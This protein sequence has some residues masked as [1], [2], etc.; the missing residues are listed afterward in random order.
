MSTH[1]T[2]AQF[3]QTTTPI[4]FAE[5]KTRI[6]THEALSL[7]R[8]RDMVSALATMAKAM[9]LP[10]EFL[11][12][13]PVTLRPRLATMTAAKAGVRPGR[14]RNVMSLVASAMALEGI[15]RIQGRTREPLAPAWAALLAPLDTTPGAHFHIWRFARF[16]GGK[17][18]T[19]EGVTDAILADYLHDLTHFSLASEPD[20]GAREV[21][22][23]WNTLADNQSGWPGQKL[24]V[25]DNRST[26]SLPWEALPANL[27]QDVDEWL[28]A[29]ADPDPF[30]ERA[31]PTRRELRPRSLATRKQQVRLLIG[32]L[33]QKGVPVNELASLADV[34]RLDRT[35][36]ALSF[37]WERAECKPTLHAG[38]LADVVLMIA[39]HWV[40]TSPTDIAKLERMAERLRPRPSGMADRNV[41]RLRQLEHPGRQKALLT[42][43]AR[44][45]EAARKV[46]RPTLR[47]AQQVQIAAAIELLLHIPLRISNL[48]T[49]QLGRDLRLDSDGSY[50]LRIVFRR[51][52]NRV[53]IEGRLQGEAAR[54]MKLYLE[55]YRPLL[56][57]EPSAWLFPGANP[58]THKTEDGLRS[59]IEKAVAVNTGMDIHPHLF[60][61]IA[62][63]LILRQN[64]GN[65]GMVQRLL[66]HASLATTMKYYSALEAAIAVERYD[67]L[68]VSLREVSDDS[69]P[70][71]RPPRRPRGS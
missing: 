2:A 35:R 45:L 51:V 32:A 48:I 24:T 12:A 63:W 56:E 11:A 22:R 61:H 46:G 59:A 40:A 1:D 58:G 7:T 5:L 33:V 3:R 29:L 71:C 43:P 68:I 60:R 6:M 26:Y 66:G 69:G 4:T 39:R 65:H 17:G 54:L 37:F 53:A 16:C 28:A 30:S 25:P 9:G 47:L 36:L 50:V 21:A 19:P 8:R 62:A 52:K 20:R 23:A 38:Q 67:A 18:I 31:L 41:E 55:R 34:V 10:P 42:L 64:P 13:E 57:R 70:G 27:V 14:W 49:L 44:M 15:V